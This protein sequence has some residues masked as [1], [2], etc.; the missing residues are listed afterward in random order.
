MGMVKQ[1]LLA[2]NMVKQKK[3]YL[4]TRQVK[5]PVQVVGAVHF[6]SPEVSLD[7]HGGLTPTQPS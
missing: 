7:F 1:V 5:T 3:T 2:C 6:D 4:C